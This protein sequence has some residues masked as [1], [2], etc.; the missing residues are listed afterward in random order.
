MG[1]TVYPM[2]DF[3][4]YTPPNTAT[5]INAF[6]DRFFNIFN[7]HNKILVNVI[8]TNLNGYLSVSRS[9]FLTDFLPKFC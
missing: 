8:R 6:N 4:I 1:Q 3:V 2:E 7:F 5:A 9:H